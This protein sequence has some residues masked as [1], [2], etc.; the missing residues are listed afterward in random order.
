MRQISLSENPISP[1]PVNKLDIARYMYARPLDFAPGT[2]YKYSNYGYLLLSAV[3]EHV[4]GMD[5]FEYVQN[6][7][8]EPAGITEVLL[9]STLASQRTAHEAICEDEGLGLS[10]TNLLS[11][12]LVPA[13][14]GGDGQIKEVAAG[15]VGIAASATAL[16]QFIHLHAVWGNGPRLA[17]G[18][19]WMYTRTG[20][21]PGTSTLACSRGD[22]IDWA[23][24]INTRD[25]P[26]QAPHA[27][28]GLGT[29][30]NALLNTTP[31]P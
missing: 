12:L 10:P 3:V 9:S 29:S 2:N 30:I 27:P 21:T 16:T 31:I 14:Y 6:T 18:G 13:V 20:S 24:V 8:L 23:Y 1:R 4:T 5:F 22:G 15:C 26:P 17:D 28:D 7:L 11:Q 25:W 19:S